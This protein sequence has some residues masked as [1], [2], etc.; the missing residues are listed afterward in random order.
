MDMAKTAETQEQLFSRLWETYGHCCW[1]HTLNNAAACAAALVFGKGDF[2][3]TLSAVVSCGWDTDC[4]GASLGS[5]MGALYGAKAIP[6]ANHRLFVCPDF[7]IVQSSSRRD[8]PFCGWSLCF[9][10]DTG[11]A[12][13]RCTAENCD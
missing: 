8:H 6:E 11:G 3:R 10:D 9:A 7:S 13:G 2:T 1:V 12:S 5:V 4:N